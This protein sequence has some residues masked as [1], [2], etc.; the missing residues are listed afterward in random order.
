MH[1]KKMLLVGMALFGASEVMAADAYLRLRCEGVSEG[2]EVRIN[3]Q[4]KGQCP[5]DLAVP[6]GKIR[7]S[8]RKDLGRGQYQLYEKDLFLA[9]NAMK[10]ESVVMDGPILFTP[11]GRKL[12]DERL[13]AAAAA[14][15]VEAERLAAEREAARLQ[16]ER[17]APRIA[18]E[19]EAA[20]RAA[21]RAQPGMTKT[22]INGMSSHCPEAGR[23]GRCPGGSILP[24]VA[25]TGA[26][27][28]L[29]L[30]TST[31]VAEGKSLVDATDPAVFA[32][33]DAMIA[34]ATRARSTREAN[35]PAEL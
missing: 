12:E 26:P 10:R 35:P 27:F 19:K 30:S 3:G 34:R 29:P 31:D 32:N 9:G 20:R 5:I 1:C 4:L 15:K 33:P 16:A 28:A 6:E 17:D 23:G 21:I 8:V 13:A 2:A 18:A 25:T 11:Q 14:A 22:W 7:L 24:L